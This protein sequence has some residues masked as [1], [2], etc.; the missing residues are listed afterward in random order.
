MEVMAGHKMES[1]APGWGPAFHAGGFLPSPGGAAPKPSHARPGW[2]L[3]SQVG[4]TWEKG[5]GRGWGGQ[6]PRLHIAKRLSFNPD[7]T[8]TSC[9]ASMSK[10]LQVTSS[11]KNLTFLFVGNP[12]NSPTSK[13]YWDVEMG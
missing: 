3:W 12:G 4:R 1:W 5:P 7:S 8:L 2:H 13:G 11:L 10:L 9:V 6:M